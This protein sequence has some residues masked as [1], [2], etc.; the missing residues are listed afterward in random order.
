MKRTPHKALTLADLK[1][2]ELNAN[3]GTVRGRAALRQSL[4]SYGAGRSILLDKHGVIIGGHKAVEQAKTLG[5]PLKIVPTDGRVVVGVLRTDLDLKKDT[6]ARALAIAD[7]RVAQLDLDW[8][9]NVLDQLRANG[10]DLSLWW[11]DR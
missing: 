7:N 2:D 11:T 10:F 4:E 8:D 3:R 1:P 6:K 5:F 9:G